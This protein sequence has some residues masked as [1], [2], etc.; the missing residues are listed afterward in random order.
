[1]AVRESWNSENHLENE[2]LFQ[3]HHLILGSIPD[4]SHDGFEGIRPITVGMSIVGSEEEEYSAKSGCRQDN[5]GKKKGG[6]QKSAP[7][8]SIDSL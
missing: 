8:T 6:L 7:P 1:V 5:I 3:V 4:S 2:T